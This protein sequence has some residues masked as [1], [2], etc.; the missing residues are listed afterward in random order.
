VNVGPKRWI[1]AVEAVLAVGRH[2]HQLV[3]VD[4]NVGAGAVDAGDAELLDPRLVLHAQVVL[5]VGSD[6]GDVFGKAAQE[7]GLVHSFGAA[8]DHGD[9]LVGDLIAVADGQ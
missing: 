9:L 5:A 8:A 3:F 4:P 7:N 6:Q 1:D 2:H